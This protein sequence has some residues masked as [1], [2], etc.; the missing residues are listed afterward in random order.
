MKYFSRYITSTVSI[1]E[2]MQCSG[3]KRQNKAVAKQLQK[4]ADMDLATRHSGTWKMVMSKT[5]GI[6][7]YYNSVTNECTW[8]VPSESSSV[9]VSEFMNLFMRLVS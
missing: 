9:P 5:Y 2:D 4:T 8:T 6:P 3:A 1:A 7:Y